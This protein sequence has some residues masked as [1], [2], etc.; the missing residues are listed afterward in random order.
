MGGLASKI[1][2]VR[3]RARKSSRK[4]A[5]QRATARA[6]TSLLRASRFSGR[7]VRRASAKSSKAVVSSWDDRTV[8]LELSLTQ[9][10]LIASLRE[11]YKDKAGSL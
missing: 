8:N 3:S 10:E 2:C 9:A 11:K 5:E 4:G 6:A 1:T 7:S